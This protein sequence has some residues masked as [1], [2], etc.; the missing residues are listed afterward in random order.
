MQHNIQVPN[1]KTCS[2]APSMCSALYIVFLEAHVNKYAV[3]P[4]LQKTLRS[5]DTSLYL[6]P[7][8]L[9]ILVDKEH[10]Q[11]KANGYDMS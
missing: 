10:S 6:F 3:E 9:I 7:P 2:H 8:V 5:K 4:L 11:V 1:M